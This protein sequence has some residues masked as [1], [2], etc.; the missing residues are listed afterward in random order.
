M[1]YYGSGSRETVFSETDLREG[2]YQALERLGSRHKVIAVGPDITRFHSRAGYLT[3]LAWRY[4]GEALRDVLPALGTHAPMTADQMDAMYTGIPHELFRVHDWRNELATLG[5]VPATKVRELS[6]GKL[7]FEWPAQVNRRLVEGGYDLILSIGQVVPHEVI[8]MANY[9]KN[10][11]VG[12]GG[13][14][15]INFSHY[16]GAVYGMERLMGEIDSPVRA[17]LDY[18]SDHFSDQLP[19][20][21]YVLTVVSTDEDGRLQVRGLFI[22]DDRECYEKAARLSQE[23]NITRVDKPLPNVVAYMDPSEYHSTWIA[24]KAVYRTRMAIADGGRLTVIA[25]GVKEF[26]EDPEIDRLIRKYGY[27]GTERV[28]DLVEKNQE[29][30]ENLGTAA[31]LIHGSTEG[32]FSVVY[33]PGHLSRSE[34]EKV[35]Y[36]YGD[37]GE[38]MERY[39]PEGRAEGFHQLPDGEEFYLIKN[40]ALG[41][42]T[43]GDSG[44]RV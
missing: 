22:G 8:G 39:N 42:W 26:G 41:L 21:V 16:L 25:P 44:R 18:T 29:L 30:R 36:G 15:G 17:L 27:V 11:F 3:A 9:N 5:V 6:E 20:V 2:L 13:R 10:L 14:E 37:L 40:P 4:Y 23:V 34:I 24:N 28:L 43:F 35:N 33:C 31:H 7:D 32:R 1:L 12:T 38:M 19:Q